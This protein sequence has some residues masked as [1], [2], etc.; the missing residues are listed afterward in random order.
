MKKLFVSLLFLSPFFIAG[1]SK[2][3]DNASIANCEAKNY[4][5]VKVSFG[6]INIKHGILVTQIGS[7]S[8]TRE[9][10]IEAGKG[11][12]TIRLVPGSY[13]IN[14]ARINNSNQAIEDQTFTNRN[15][16]Q[17]QEMSFHVA[18]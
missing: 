14:V 7:E 10:I 15:I 11:S 17:C 9:K 12:D 1:C 13:H 6:D 8:I 18:F 16:V 4:G 3:D 5:V 2:D